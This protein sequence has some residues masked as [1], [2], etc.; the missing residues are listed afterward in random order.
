[1][2]MLPVALFCGLWYAISGW[3]PGYGTHDMFMLP[4]FAS[5]PIGLIMGKVPEAMMYGSAISMMYVGMVAPGS[6]LPA[7]SALA[8][9]VGIPIALAI[10]A[11][12]ATAVLIA[13]PFG[14]FGVFL[15][16]LRRIINGRFATYADKCAMKADTAGISRA[17]IL[18][19]LLM[20]LITKFPVAFGIVYFGAD[21]AQKVVDLCPKWIMHGFSVA[22]GLLPAIGFGILLLVMGKKSLFAFFFI[23]FFMVEYLHLSTIAIVCF[24][25]PVAFAVVLISME[26]EEQV[27]KQAAKI[28]SKNSSDDDDDDED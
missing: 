25:I 10:G 5:L 23:G 4:L 6:E 20:N 8:G 16:T 26:Q 12:T 7:D 17:A 22:G 11:D 27:L 19:P 28:A 24:A 13:V 15:N 3:R 18:F 2:N 14:V 21:A 9:L 1:M